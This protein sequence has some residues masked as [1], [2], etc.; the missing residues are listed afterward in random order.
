MAWQ[1]LYE[2]LSTL[3]VAELTGTQSFFLKFCKALLVG[4]RW[5]LYLQ[6]LRFTLELTVIALILGIVL[7]VV[8]AVIRTSHDQQRPGR[9]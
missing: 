1:A 7:G 4:D 5:K 6:G 8:V 2:H 3:P 9:R